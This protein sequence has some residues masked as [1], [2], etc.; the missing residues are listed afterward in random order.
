MVIG[1]IYSI[2][3][4]ALHVMVVLIPWRMIYIPCWVENNIT[5]LLT[6]T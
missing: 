4:N 2:S 1:M 5:N 6:I 3:L